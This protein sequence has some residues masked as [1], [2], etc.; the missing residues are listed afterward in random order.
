M[1]IGKRNRP[2]V[3]S[4]LIS[5]AD[6]AFLLIF[7]FL[8]TS[9]FMKDRVKVDLP[10]LPRMLKTAVPH[11]VT[12][13]KNKQIFFDGELVTTKEDLEGRVKTALTGK[14]KPEDL[15]I[16]FKCDK[17]MPFKEYRPVIEAIASAGGTLAIIH[18]TP[19][20]K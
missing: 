14:T 3:E 18:D 1:N 20:S 2:L 17:T 15:E 9:S 5:L 13:D 7:F 19:S 12:L 11:S 16:R 8:L 4:Q 6:I 10:I